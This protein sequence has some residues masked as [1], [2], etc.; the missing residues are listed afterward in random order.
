MFL[1]PNKKD[2]ALA[3]IDCAM[4][5]RTFAQMMLDEAEKDLDKSKKLMEEWQAE[6]AAVNE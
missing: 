4:R 3:L 5:K 1:K 6:E 2:Q